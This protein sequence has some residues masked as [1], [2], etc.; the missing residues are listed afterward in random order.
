MICGIGGIGKTTLAAELVGRVLDRESRILVSLTGPLTLEGLLGA[1]TSAIRRQLLVSGEQ[2][3]DVLRALDVVAR[4][5]VGWQ[6]RF[7]VLRDYVLG[8]VPTLVLLDNFED[9]LGPDRDTG[10]IVADEV[11]SEL[12]AAWAATRAC[13]GS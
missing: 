5:D 9:N 6:D 13:R 12:L 1:V 8:R 3:T 10:W 11:L 2:A 7:A 4:A